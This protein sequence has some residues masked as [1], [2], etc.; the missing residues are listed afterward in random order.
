LKPEG[1]CN[2]PL[3]GLSKP[4]GLVGAVFQEGAIQQ[5]M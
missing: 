1:F 5:V 3:K 4:E 2:A